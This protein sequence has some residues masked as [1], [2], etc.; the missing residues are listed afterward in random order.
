MNTRDLSHCQR[1]G[2][3]RDYTGEPLRKE[4][5]VVF[6]RHLTWDAHVSDVVRKCV[7][8]L[9]GLRHLRSFLPQHAML[10]IVRALVVSPV[11]YCYLCMGMVRL[12]TWPG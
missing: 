10:A 3:W 6:D 4:L 8:L 9:V 7:G 2:R 11:S 1:A 5:G 12:P